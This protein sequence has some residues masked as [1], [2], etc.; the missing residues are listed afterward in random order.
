MNKPSFIA[1]QILHVLKSNWIIS[2]LFIALAAVPS[3]MAVFNDEKLH[4]FVT[5]DPLRTALLGIAGFVIALVFMGLPNFLLGKSYREDKVLASTAALNNEFVQEMKEI[6]NSVK[7]TEKELLIQ[8]LRP[9]QRNI[10]NHLNKLQYN[11]IVNLMIG[12]VGT[13]ISVAVILVTLLSRHDDVSMEKFLLE[14]LPRL[15]F[16]VFIQLF[17]FFFLR[18][19]KGNLEDSKYFQNELTN[20]MAKAISI[21]IASQIGD[22][23]LLKELMKELFKT[24][25]NFKL[26]AG[27][28]L[29]NI[30]KNK[31]EKDFDLE[32]LNAMKD[33]FKASK[34][35]D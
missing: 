32:L 5:D 6:R 30:E 17:S 23:D 26:A 35:K 9:L 11:S 31:I 20:I 28:T 25:R 21:K 34:T 2:T 3:I 22:K 19:Y 15:S 14:F 12:I 1:R 18:L 4:S 8:T 7:L 33:F 29:L 10:E 27:E 24:E 13:T 16:V